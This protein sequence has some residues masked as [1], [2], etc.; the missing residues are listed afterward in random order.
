MIAKRTSSYS[1]WQRRQLHADFRA[2]RIF[3]HAEA[4][5]LVKKHY[6]MPKRL[7]EAQRKIRAW[8]RARDRLVDQL[9]RRIHRLK[10][11]TETVILYGDSVEKAVAAYNAFPQ[12]VA[13]EREKFKA[14]KLKVR[15]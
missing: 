10:E 13:R 2:L 11:A 8:E 3:P 1:H 12:S 4:H 5:A 6:P 14:E 7:R 15:R 9:S